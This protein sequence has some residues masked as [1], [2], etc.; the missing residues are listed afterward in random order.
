MD[1]DVLV[2]QQL[3][4]QR[5]A[6][7]CERWRLDYDTAM[8]IRQDATGDLDRMASW[9]TDADRCK[10]RISECAR[11]IRD[12]VGDDIEESLMVGRGDEALSDVRKRNL[13]L[14]D[15]MRYHELAGQQGIDCDSRLIANEMRQLLATWQASMDQAMDLASASSTSLST[16]DQPTDAAVAA[17]SSNLSLVSSSMD[18]MLRAVI[19]MHGIRD[20]TP[21]MA[22]ARAVVQQAAVKACSQARSLVDACESLDERRDSDVIAIRDRIRDDVERME[23]AL[24]GKVEQER[25]QQD[26]EQSR[27][28]ADSVIARRPAPRHREPGQPDVPDATIESQPTLE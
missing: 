14:G 20:N 4:A 28:Q 10:D 18:D 25:V 11:D 16:A 23:Q 3:E 17:A 24:A 15:G 2:R 1:D 9:Q 5:I 22:N 12:L 13:S 26:A 27:Q 8:L 7:E 6:N 21:A 19:A